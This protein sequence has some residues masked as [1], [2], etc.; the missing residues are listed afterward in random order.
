M[1]ELTSS[2]REVARGLGVSNT[3]MHE[4]YWNN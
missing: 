4:A 1:A 2:T 3:N